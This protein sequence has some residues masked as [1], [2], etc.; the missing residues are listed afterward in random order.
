MG[1]VI[2][3]GPP[4]K[5]DSTTVRRTMTTRT[6]SPALAG[7]QKYVSQCTKRVNAAAVRGPRNLADR[8]VAGGGLDEQVRDRRRQHFSQTSPSHAAAVWLNGRR[9]VEAVAGAGRRDVQEP[10][11]VFPI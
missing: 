3:Q 1:T 8:F 2:L 10:L 9:E 6:W 4:V 7:R 5:A 11:G